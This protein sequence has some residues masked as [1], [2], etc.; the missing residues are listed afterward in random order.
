MY[1][2][3]NVHF[4]VHFPCH[5]FFIKFAFAQICQVKNTQPIKGNPSGR[6]VPLR[7]PLG[8][9]PAA[10]FPPWRCPFP[11]TPPSASGGSTATDTRRRAWGAGDPAGN[12]LSTLPFFC[13][14]LKSCK[15]RHGGGCKLVV[16]TFSVSYGVLLFF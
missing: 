1:F 15:S 2:D 12:P 4:P 11:R 10:S 8:P 3:L 16:S 13:Q 6:S 14:R 7:C 9:P 5:Q